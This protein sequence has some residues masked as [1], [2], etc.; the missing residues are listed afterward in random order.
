[1]ITVASKPSGGGADTPRCGTPRLRT[2]RWQRRRTWLAVSAAGL[3]LSACS[4]ANDGASTES[5]GAVAQ[6]TLNV[7]LVADIQNLDPAFMVGSVDDAVMLNVAENL[8]TFRPGSTELMNEL[9]AEF[10]SSDDGLTHE[11]RLKE[12]I[13]FHGGF[14]EVTAEDVKFSY[15]RIAGLTEPKIESP[16]QGDWAALKEV[17]VTG[18]YTGVIRLA[19]PFAPLLLTTLPGH[20]GMV[21]SKAAFEERGDDFATNPVGSGPYEFVE[22]KRGQHVLLRRF[23]DWG[24]AGSEIAAEPQWKEIRFR[25]ITDDSA[26]DIA[27]ETGDVQ[28]GVVPPAS[29][30]RFSNDD[31]FEITK[32]TTLDYGWIGFNVTHPKLADVRVRRAIRQALDIDAMIEA[33]FEGQVTRAH[34]LIAPDMP[35]G[36]WA[37][38]PEQTRDVE[39]AKRMLGEAGVK[40]LQLEMSIAEEPGS[41]VIA[42]VVQA[43]LADIGID[44][45]IRVRAEGELKEQVKSLEMFYTSFSNQADPSWATVWFTG[46]QVGTW[47]FMSWAN[48]EFDS[49]HDAALAEVD[50]DKRSDM[51]VRMQQIMEEEAVAAWV[52]Y[53]TQ[54]YAGATGLEPSLVTPR[55]GKYR[56]WAT[57]ADGE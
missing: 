9:A 19:Q 57:T 48:A 5:K 8:V 42:E 25:P 22:W 40:G 45:S 6:E 16:Y 32:Q 38:A 56:A 49:L 12:G 20:A 2:Q 36:H 29:I 10:T 35:I 11:F 37:D 46:D 17:E 31:R 23:D 4:V 47:N 18:K 41:R 34:A 39:A 1:M 24:G 53:R 15:E 3:I 43:N 13:P 30:E 52:M 28:F 54:N 26:A 50:P 44:V 33:A 7:R 27:V 14:G 55:Y 21:I 51:Y